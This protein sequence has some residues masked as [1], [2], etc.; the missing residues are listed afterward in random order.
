MMELIKAVGKSCKSRVM[1]LTEWEAGML[2]I[3]AVALNVV[4]L[5]MWWL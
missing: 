5:A 4:L 3:A 1:H 2:F